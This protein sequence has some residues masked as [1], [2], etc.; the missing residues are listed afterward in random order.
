MEILEN[1]NTVQEWFSENLPAIISI[2]SVLIALLVWRETKRT[3]KSSFYPD[4]ILTDSS[5]FF[6]INNSDDKEG[7]LWGAKLFRFKDKVKN[8]DN[9]NE[10]Y[11]INIG[12]GVA[13]RIQVEWVYNLKDFV[14]Q[15]KKINESKYRLELANYDSFDLLTLYD[16]QNRDLLYDGASKSDTDNEFLYYLIPV[17]QI[18]D[19]TQY[20]TFPES[21]LK[22]YFYYGMMKFDD[23]NP[24]REEFYV[25]GFEEIKKPIVKLKYLDVQNNTHQKAFDLKITAYDRLSQDLPENELSFYL[26]I[27]FNEIN[28]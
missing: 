28:N 7:Y 23:K 14:T 21:L 1:I 24:L 26:D 19:S 2:S 9:S 4:I 3:R 18:K 6:E 5:V 8:Y 10:I 12:L 13:K 15:Q 16:S 17:H 20:I 22:A 11:P 25:E 27:K